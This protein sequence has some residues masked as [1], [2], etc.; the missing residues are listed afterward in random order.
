[1]NARAMVLLAGVGLALPGLAAAQTPLDQAWVNAGFYSLHFKRDEGLQDFNPGLGVEW[2]LDDT[3]SLT[4]GAFY[5][6]DRE[7]SGYLGLYMMPLRW[8]PAKFGVVTGVF[9]G[10]PNYFGGRAFPAIL[11]VVAIEGRNWGLNVALIPEIK[12]QLHG[13]I[14]FQLKY[15][16]GA[17]ADSGVSGG[18]GAPR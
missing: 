14:S 18:S 6:S 5:N 16:F 2:P 12:D 3:F 15:R 9:S 10:Y 11:P 17:P 7:T 8:G 4:A 1:M 13:A